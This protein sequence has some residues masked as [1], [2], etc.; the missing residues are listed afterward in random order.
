MEV[1]KRPPHRH[2][3]SAAALIYYYN[4]CNIHTRAKMLRRDRT[5]YSDDGDDLD[6]DDDDLDDYNLYGGGWEEEGGKQE[7]RVYNVGD[8]DLWRVH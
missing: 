5:A 1:E 2:V 4:K 8:N 3:T 6:D 7:V